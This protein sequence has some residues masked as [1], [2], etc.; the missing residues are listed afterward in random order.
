MMNNTTMVDMSNSNQHLAGTPDPEQTGSSNASTG[1][2][3]KER[4]K[5]FPEILHDLL[6]YGAEDNDVSNIVM[7]LPSGA[8]FVIFEPQKFEAVVLPKFFPQ[9]RY[10]SFT[11]K[12]NRWGFRQIAKGP[13]RGAFHHDLFHK[14]NPQLCLQMTCVKARKTPA[15]DDQARGYLNFQQSY[16]NS[17]SS[18]SLG[19]SL[20]PSSER[21]RMGGMPQGLANFPHGGGGAGCNNFSSVSTESLG[22]MLRKQQQALEFQ[23]AKLNRQKFIIE[24]QA[25]ALQNGMTP[26]NDDIM[27][28]PLGMAEEESA[29]LRAAGSS[30]NILQQ[31]GHFC[32]IQQSSQDAEQLRDLQPSPLNNAFNPQEQLRNMQNSS[33]A[34]R[35]ELQQDHMSRT[36]AE[37]LQH[38]HFGHQMRPQDN[39]NSS[40]DFQASLSQHLQHQS[41]NTRLPVEPSRDKLD[42]AQDLNFDQTALLRYQYQQK[43]AI[44]AL[45]AKSQESF[46]GSNAAGIHNQFSMEPN[47][48]MGSNFSPEELYQLAA[49]QQQQS[50]GSPFSSNASLK[51]RDKKFEGGRAA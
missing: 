40:M 46:G 20:S 44:S 37:Q 5:V 12:L 38:Q 7:W 41:T 23:R 51:P 39:M 24:N 50:G 26:E 3:P 11:R 47:K 27:D 19:S 49:M 35:I 15:L 31:M 16:G 43:M 2:K 14:D 30:R 28:N 48:M 34:G 8:A 10:A 17:L 21:M 32:D 33:E 36:R 45:H 18:R 22:E 4:K 13:D 29:M 6:S 25:L 1:S 9:S 42:F